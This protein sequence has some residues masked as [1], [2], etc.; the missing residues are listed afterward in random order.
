[1]D[2]YDVIII[3]GG[4]NGLACGYQFQKEMPSNKVLILEKNKILNSLRNYPDVLWHSTMKELKLP[5]YLNHS[6]EDEYSPTSSELVKY[7]E[8][9]SKEHDLNILENHEV[10]D[11]E[12]IAQ[13]NNQTSVRN[14]MYPRFARSR[15]ILVYTQRISCIYTR[16]SSAHAQEIILCILKRFSCLFVYAQ[17][18]HLCAHEI[19]SFV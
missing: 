7:Y 18:H 10:I 2:Q 12:R 15:E 14:T 13:K 9:F 5:S 11:I 4:P 6:I 1:M 17:E 8:N 3:G 19:F 16:Q